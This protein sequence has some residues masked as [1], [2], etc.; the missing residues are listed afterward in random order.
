MGS[1]EDTD[2][3]PEWQ[4]RNKHLSKSLNLVPQDF[5]SQL[6]THLPLPQLC[7]KNHHIFRKII[8]R[9]EGPCADSQI[10]IFRQGKKH[11]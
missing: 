10:G 9:K 11:R 5:K 1:H 3:L 4:V 6:Q 8:T 7:N 2:R